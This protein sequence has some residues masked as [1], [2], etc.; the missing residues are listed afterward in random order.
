MIE[1]PARINSATL[2]PN[3]ALKSSECS[4]SLIILIY[5]ALGIL[6]DSYFQ[7]ALLNWIVCCVIL[8]ISWVVCFRFRWNTY[9]TKILLLAI[10]CLGGMRQHEFWCCQAPNNISRLFIENE[11]P[12]QHHLPNRITPK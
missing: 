1:S 12:D 8:T 6:F 5:F 10:L 4:P 2:K 9:E 7:P 3:L 11:Q